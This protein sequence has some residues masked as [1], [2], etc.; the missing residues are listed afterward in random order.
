[1]K[2]LLLA[3]SLLVCAPLLAQDTELFD[4]S[5]LN[6]A[7]P[8]VPTG[9]A[10]ILS[11]LFIDVDDEATSLRVDL[12]DLSGRDVDVLLAREPFPDTITNLNMLFNSAEY[13]SAGASGEE[14]VTLQNSSNPPLAGQRWHLAVVAFE[15]PAGSATLSTNIS[16]GPPAAAQMVVDFDNSLGADN[17]DTAPWNDATAFTPIDGN[18][19]TTLGAARRNAM[20]EAMRLL[21]MQLT[22]P[23]P[24]IIRGCWENLGEGD[25]GATLAGARTNFIFINTPG[26]PLS[27]TLYFQALVSRHAGAA[28]CNIG[29]GVGCGEQDILIGFNTDVDSD[30]ALGPRSWYYGFTGPSDSDVDF[31]STVIHEIT[32]GLGFA[33]TIGEDGVLLSLG[34]QPRGDSFSQ[35]LVDNSAGQ[36]V[37][38]LD[39][40]MTDS[41]RAAAL[42][43]GNGL[44]WSGPESSV[45]NFNRFNSNQDDGFIRMYAPDPFEPG[46]SVSH[47]SRSYCAVMEPISTDCGPG[48]FRSLGLEQAMLHELGWAPAGNRPPLLG[49]YFDRARDGHGFDFQLGGVDP[50]LGPI[51]VLTFY[52]YRTQGL[53]P[54]WFQA[55]GPIQNGVFYGLRSDLTAGLGFPSFTYDDGRD[56]PQQA[57]ADRFGQVTLSL[58]SPEASAACNDGVD[59]PGVAVYSFQWALDNSLGEWCVETV[60]GTDTRPNLDNGGLWFAGQAD[61]GWGYSLENIERP[62]GD[63]DLFVLLYVYAGDGTPVWFFGFV[64]AAD[65]ANP[66]EFEMF[67]RTGFNRLTTFGSIV[68]E[69]AGSLTLVL[70][71]DPTVGLDGSNRASVDV[72]FQGAEAGDWFRDDVPVVRLS[73]PRD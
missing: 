2:G 42:I 65:L 8:M 37:P 25:D 6:L 36:A 33:S 61:Q 12:V 50:Q 7:L 62:N 46:S 60:P 18:S 11:N 22:S 16:Q 32:H 41:G 29:A 9:Q 59:R 35:H 43:S 44:Q 31:I 15:G 4:G 20:L 54:E 70:G 51:Y 45:S 73:Q 72:T 40:S 52:S 71:G 26:L 39:A 27:D 69:S 38:L 3:L 56:P 67:Q 1:M 30:V 48:E 63:I 49:L 58:N 34:G 17:C 57:D 53:E 24:I 23:V 21:S 13:L 55:A 64:A 14:F 47:V 19:A 28:V 5:S 66:V 68:D 10:I